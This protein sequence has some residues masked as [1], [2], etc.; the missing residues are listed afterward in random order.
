MSGLQSEN[1]TLATKQDI[2]VTKQ[3]L[4]AFE[5]RLSKKIG[6]FGSD[7]FKWM[8]IFWVGQIAA[9]FGL[10]LLFLKK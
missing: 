9:T 7:M 8:F 1:D 5:A 10:I 2:I 6:G 3:D 4:A